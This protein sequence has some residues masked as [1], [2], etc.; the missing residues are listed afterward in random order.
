MRRNLLLLNLLLLALIGLVSWRLWAGYQESSLRQ[1]T[2][3][4]KTTPIPP[5]P[6]VVFPAHPSQ[7]SA[8]NYY[9]VAAKLPFSKDRNP[10]VIV[11]V[12]AQKPMPALPRYYGMMNFGAGPRVILSPGPGG[13]QKSYVEGESVGDFKLVAIA[14]SG[15]TFEWEGKKVPARYEDMKDNTPAQQPAGA[16]APVGMPAMQSVGVVNAAP[17]AQAAAPT[18]VTGVGGAG[19]ARP[20][21][22]IGASIKGCQPGDS[23]PAGV[24]MDGYRKVVTE[25]P[26]GKSCRWERV[27]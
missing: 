7:V 25:T 13:K 24:V 5:P 10:T 19:A 16:S 11:E 22:D 9:E 8:A 17:Q 14:N 15:L 4:S 3:L 18:T 6:N 27:H 23:S 26:F 20:G 21:A 12:E 2:F 1:K